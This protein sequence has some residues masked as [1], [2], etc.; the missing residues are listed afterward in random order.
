LG[1]GGGRAGEDSGC[2]GMFAG[3]RSEWGLE[4]ILEAVG[5]LGAARLHDGEGT[6]R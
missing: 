5:C 6:V 2:S 1:L 3:R 4:G